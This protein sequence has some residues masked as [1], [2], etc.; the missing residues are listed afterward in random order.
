MKKKAPTDSLTPLELYKLRATMAEAKVHEL[1]MKFT[2]IQRREYLAKIDPAGKLQWFESTIQ[3]LGHKMSE[4][5]EEVKQIQ[6]EIEDRIGAPLT[7][8]AY[9]D[10]TG[11]LTKM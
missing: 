7:D 9:D 2:D 6:S 4:S 8:F 3:A 11:K 10:L 1:Q 5:L